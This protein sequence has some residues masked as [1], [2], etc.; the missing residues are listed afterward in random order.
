MTNPINKIEPYQ[1]DT[2]AS[3]TF[4]NSVTLGNV[5]NV[6]ISG[7]TSGQY[8]KTDGSG[9]LSFSDINIPS[10]FLLMGA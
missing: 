8:I 1:I 7:G 2:A 4:S 10:Q 3:I 6:H 5:G 9:N